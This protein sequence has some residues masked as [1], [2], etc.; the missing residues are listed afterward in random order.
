MSDSLS[1][2]PGPRSLYY[3]VVFGPTQPLKNYQSSSR[4]RH[5]FLCL[6][7]PFFI[8][9]RHVLV[10]IWIF[11]NKYM[12]L[13]NYL[14]F[15]VNPATSITFSF[16]VNPLFS[17]PMVSLYHPFAQ[18]VSSLCCYRLV[19]SIMFNVVR[20]NDLEPSSDNVPQWPT[21]SNRSALDGLCS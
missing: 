15:C 7:K 17:C 9:R 20:W 4:S 3:E 13:Y 2:S 14:P 19:F 16:S 1:S 10:W 12:I 6:H 21:S 18:L 11:R 8:W 5:P